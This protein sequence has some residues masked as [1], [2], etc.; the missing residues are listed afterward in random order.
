MYRPIAESASG[1]AG[2][3]GAWKLA[4]RTA[5]AGEQA[6]GHGTAGNG[7]AQNGEREQSGVKEHGTGAAF[8]RE[9]KEFG[10]GDGLRV[11]SEG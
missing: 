8:G 2:S 10:G 7:K 11:H 5:G 4:L 1:G 3:G 9:H 6:R